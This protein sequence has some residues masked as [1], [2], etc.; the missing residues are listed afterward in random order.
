MSLSLLSLS[1][2]PSLSL[3]LCV[4]VC[5]CCHLL[6]PAARHTAGQHGDNM[7]ST[8]DGSVDVMSA[9]LRVTYLCEVGEGIGDGECEAAVSA[10]V[11][12]MLSAKTTVKICQLQA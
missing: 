8:F 4:C 3:S 5:V 6:Q 2:S 1:L 12:L 9:S 7:G 10:G 11:N